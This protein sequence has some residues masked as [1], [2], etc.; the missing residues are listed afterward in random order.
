M[1]QGATRRH[2]LL[3]YAISNNSPLNALDPTG[4][5]GIAAG[6]GPGLGQLT[7]ATVGAP[8]VPSPQIINFTQEEFEEQ[9][10]ILQAKL[11]YKIL[12][13]DIRRAYLID[14]IQFRFYLRTL[15][16]KQ[17]RLREAE[18]LIVP[19][20]AEVIRLREKLALLEAI[21][22]DVPDIVIDA[23]I[24]SLD[25]AVDAANDKI[26]DAVS[27]QNDIQELEERWQPFFIQYA[28][29]DIGF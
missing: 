27:I 28:E 19:L 13:G 3:L 2:N 16:L 25:A 10:R 11:G 4:C 17:Q 29:G 1:F 18:A 8:P 22:G 5:A 24:E 6:I 9:T 12:S 15:N 26:G 23:T 20:Q 21:G 7:S 14:R